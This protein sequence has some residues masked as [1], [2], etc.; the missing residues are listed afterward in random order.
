MEGSD[1][2]PTGDGWVPGAY[3]VPTRNFGGKK[4]IKT[5]S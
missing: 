2:D 5:G 3:R 1:M 4:Y